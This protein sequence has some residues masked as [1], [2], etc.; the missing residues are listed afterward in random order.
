MTY[1]TDVDSV[2]V[3]EGE[4][5]LGGLS[6]TNTTLPTLLV[7]LRAFV[8]MHGIFRQWFS[9]FLQLL[10]FYGTEDLK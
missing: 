10:W 1:G 4:V 9:L 5:Q 7:C 6:Q 3:T 2:T 8:I